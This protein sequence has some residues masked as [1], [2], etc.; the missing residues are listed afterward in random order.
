MSLTPDSLAPADPPAEQPVDVFDHWRRFAPDLADRAVLFSELLPGGAHWSWRLPRGTTLRMTALEAG[1]N[2]SMVLY[3]AQEKLE[4][5]NMPDSLKAQHTAH[6]TRGHVL[7]SDM[8]RAMASITGDALGWHDPLGL[9]LDAQRMAAKYGERRYQ[10]ARNG[11]YRAGREGLLIEIGKYGLR[12]RDLV[13]PVN[14]FTR[15]EVDDEGRFRFDP[16]HCPAGAWVDLRFDMDVIVAISTA[17][18]PL[19]PAT[20]YAP[21]K[22]GVALWRSGPAAADDFCRRFRPENARALHNTDMMYLA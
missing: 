8:G 19:D 6:Y 2:L 4:R 9:L 17:P 11:M 10:E 5:Y 18:H 13:A 21:K 15:V 3:S 14:F 22:V 12:A 1:A 7:M 20:T 16:S